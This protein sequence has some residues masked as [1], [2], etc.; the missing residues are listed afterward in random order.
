AQW[1]RDDHLTR[2]AG[3]RRDQI[4]RLATTGVTTLAELAR[5]TD[6]SR[7]PT[8]QPATFEAL[9]E[10]AELQH[11]FAETGRHETRL[12]PP[13]AGRGFALLPPPSPGDL[14][15]DIEGDPFWQSDRGLEYLFGVSERVE[16][17]LRFREFWAHD[18]AQEQ[19]ALEDFVDF[20]HERLRADPNLHVYHYASY[21]PSALKRL[22][23][24][25]GTREDEVDDLLRREVLVDLF[26]VVRQALR[27]SHPRY[28][29][30]NVE[31]FFYEREADLRAGDDSILL[32]EEWRAGGD[33]AI[34]GRIAEYNE[35]DCAATYELREWLLG[36][37]E[38]AV[39]QFGAPI[40]WAESVPP[41]EAPETALET[42]E[43]RARLLRGLPEEPAG[44]A[45]RAAERWLAAQ[46]IGYHRR[47]AKPVWWAFFNRRGR[48][49]EE[50]AERDGDA[51]GGI[52]QAGPPTGTDRSLV[53]PFTFP[54]QEHKLSAGDNV[55]DPATLGPA[56]SIDA[57]DDGHGT[58]ALRRGPTLE[59]V[60]LPASLIP[61]GP[62]TTRAQ[63]AALRRLGE[64]IVAGSERY[65][66]LRSLLRRELPRVAGLAPGSAL[67]QDD[68]DAARR[69]VA[70]L[71]RSTLVVQGPP[72]SGKTY[73][74][75]RLIVHLIGL[76][77]RVGVA[78]TSHKAIH[79]LLDEV[80]RVAR[81]ERVPFRGL[82]KGSRYD[83]AYVETSDDQT[84]FSA[85]EDGVLLL[86]GTAWLFS[87][88]D[89]EEA[90]ID[91][92]FVDEA[93]QVSLADAL[94]MGTCARNLVLLGDPQQLA[95]VSQ[96]THPRGV[97]ASVLEHLLDGEETIPPERGLFLG[98]TWRMH[99]DVCGFV[100]EIS[101]EGRLHSAERCSR[102]GT[103][104]GTGL[105]FLPVEHGASRQSSREEADR[106]AEEIARLVGGTYTSCEGVTRRLTYAD[107]LVVAPYNAQVRC[108]RAALPEAV[109]V[110]TVDKF[111]G[112]EA[113]IVFFSMATS[114]GDDLP[115]NLGFLFS[116][117][118]L[119][120]AISR[121]QCLAVL[122][123]SPRLLEIRCRNV[124]EMRLV[125][126]LCRF[127]EVAGERT[128]SGSS[129]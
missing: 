79:N 114:S 2:V 82:K 1:E 22:M 87:R 38:D 101:Y 90:G 66:A 58:L 15:F 72:G 124:G 118:R 37:R 81:A 95:Q 64:S 78:S 67:P 116:R 84:A 27:H 24:E 129:P 93:G 102:Q 7:P 42:A 77:R 99:P 32:Y 45:P 70:S 19:Q 71:D 52:E 18:R 125:N 92:L 98:V 110:G 76:G 104:F 73:L 62:F 26:K 51:I 103:S 122:V 126:A 16:G 10:Q 50:L 108:L 113:P 100:S 112:Q 115:R 57:I 34:L 11:R 60:P 109:Q 97:G 119:N 121:A 6:A 56:G 86:A 29:L 63:Q 44:L 33:G 43:L 111:Q 91:T 40:A 3:M 61:G 28:S 39:R 36:L 48:S 65:G 106:I 117:N 47:E 23:G 127:V 9:R 49:P 94:A 96:G 41:P 123:A 80:E 53:H 13:Q 14:F 89:M 35:E 31:Q 59:D 30:K 105:R 46:L 25:Y 75:A 107:V 5:A 88:E 4:K 74:G 120:V 54:A 55:V 21:E 83:G 20:V 128:L 8:M 69:I 68:L 17:D 12:L 85:P